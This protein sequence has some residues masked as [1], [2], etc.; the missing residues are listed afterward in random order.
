M[1]KERGIKWLSTKMIDL[2]CDYVVDSNTIGLIGIYFLQRFLFLGRAVPVDPCRGWANRHTPTNGR[3]ARTRSLLVQDQCR[4]GNK[5][6]CGSID[7][8]GGSFVFCS[9]L[10][11]SS[12]GSSLQLGPVT[13]GDL[14][15]LSSS[16]WW[17]DLVTSWRRLGQWGWFSGYL[18]F[19]GSWW[20]DLVTSWRW[21]R[22]W[23]TGQIRFAEWVWNCWW[24][25]LRCSLQWFLVTQ[26]SITTWCLADQGVVL[27]P[28]I[29]WY[30]IHIMWLSTWWFEVVME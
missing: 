14:L 9:F 19:Y 6:W 16:N 24:M 21:P 1:Q 11:P 8:S 5:L 25:S 29:T 10:I 18:R 30:S 27:C 28:R 23:F 7:R 2:Y 26:I 20:W 3:G 4:R 13:N 15:V 12:L 17:W 22:Q